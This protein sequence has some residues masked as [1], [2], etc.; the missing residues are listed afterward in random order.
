MTKIKEPRL[1]NSR[2]SLA[3]VGYLFSRQYFHMYVFNGWSL[4]SHDF[5]FKYFRLL[6]LYWSVVFHAV[7]HN[8]IGFAYI[9]VP[10]RNQFPFRKLPYHKMPFRFAKYHKRSTF[11]LYWSHHL[12]VMAIFIAFF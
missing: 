11:L 12:I 1:N 5:I 7:F 9:Y 8:C 3:V 2:A 4:Y 10:F 6:N